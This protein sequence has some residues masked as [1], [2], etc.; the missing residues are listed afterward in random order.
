MAKQ[1][2]SKQVKSTYIKG[3]LATFESTRNIANRWFH[4]DTKA[5][6]KAIENKFK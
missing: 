4:G 3:T 5:A 1:L 2:K 6:A